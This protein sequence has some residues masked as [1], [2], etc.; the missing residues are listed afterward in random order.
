MRLDGLDRLRGL[1]IA[2]MVADHLALFAGVD[3]VRLTIG[4]V[5]VPVFFVVSGALVRR[6]TRRHLLVLA[7]GLLLPLAAPW[8]DSPNVLALNVAGAALLVLARSRPWGPALL[9]A[10]ALTFEAN[11]WH[12]P[13]GYP[14]GVLVAL[15]CLGQWVGPPALGRLGGCLPAF[16]ASPGRRPLTWYLGHVLALTA[17]VLVAG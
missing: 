2:C 17:V 11:G 4:R 16:L 12:N 8:V 15:M 9:A 1:A 10:V 14:F 5:A 7:A 6:L 3:V 13:T